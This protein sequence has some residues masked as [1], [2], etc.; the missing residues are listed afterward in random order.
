MAGSARLFGLGRGFFSLRLRR[1]LGGRCRGAAGAAGVT[2]SRPDDA[3]PPRYRGRPLEVPAWPARPPERQTSSRQRS[4]AGA[5]GAD[6]AGAAFSGTRTL[7]A[8]RQAQTLHRCRGLPERPELPTRERQIQ[9]EPTRRG[10]SLAP[11]RLAP[12]A[13]PRPLTGAA[14]C[15]EGL[16]C[17]SR[18]CG[19]SAGLLGTRTLGATGHAQALDRSRA[20]AGAAEP[21]QQVLPRPRGGFLDDQQVPRLRPWLP[22]RPVPRPASRIPLPRCPFR[23]A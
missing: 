19:R 11:G 17:R 6:A 5:A 15:G 13:M 10:R 22:L 21:R 20:A 14:R 1:R 4:S 18:R 8:G 16:G 23:A 3:R 7:R 2:S 12:P 9:P